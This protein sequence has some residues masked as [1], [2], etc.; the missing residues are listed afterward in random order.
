MLLSTWKQKSIQADLEP[1]TIRWKAIRYNGDMYE[2]TQY[3]SN[4][5]AIGVQIL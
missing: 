1:N 3:G 5:S 2:I 4:H